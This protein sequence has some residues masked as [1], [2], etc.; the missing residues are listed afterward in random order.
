MSTFSDYFSE[1]APSYA[2][3]RPRYPASLFEWLAEQTDAHE[4][5]WDC[6]TGNGQAAQSLATHFADVIASDPSH[7]QVSQ[8]V[9]V[10]NVT[11]AVM[12]AEF[13]AIADRS[14]NL[15]TVAQALHWFDLPVFFEEARRVLAPGGVIAAWTYQLLSIA[16]EIDAALNVF[17]SNT[18]GPFWPPERALVDAGYR[19]IA[20][21][22][23][24]IEP[25]GFV[26][27]A[28]W[29]LG[30]LRGFIETWSAVTRYRKARGADPV[31]ALID[32][33]AHMWG[34]PE[35]VRRVTWPLEMRVGRV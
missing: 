30:H 18:V 14:M 23:R 31:P 9:R 6:G 15:V 28:A 2:L 27:E 21:P 11:Y 13:A 22:F 20:F 7:A 12:T 26:M 3:H 4:R 10:P 5:A 24:E 34:R 16:P 32:E 19:S 1:A 25:P 8:G 17:Y 35:D 29:T 33:L